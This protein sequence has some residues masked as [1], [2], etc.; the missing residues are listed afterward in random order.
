ML[1]KACLDMISGV[2]YALLELMVNEVFGRIAGLSL[3]Q[4]TSLQPSEFSASMLPYDD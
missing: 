3:C 4:R 2:T 1:F